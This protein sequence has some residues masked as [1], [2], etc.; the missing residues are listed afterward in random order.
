MV[1]LEVGQVPLEQV[2][3]CVDGAGQPETL[4]QEVGGADAATGQ[5]VHFTRQF[6]VDV[7]CAE[8]RC[9]LL[10]PGLRP[11]PP[12]DTALAIAETIP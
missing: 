3:F 4:G 5:A 9:C 8:H 10:V 11:R 6:I 2:E 1:R 12:L 7:A